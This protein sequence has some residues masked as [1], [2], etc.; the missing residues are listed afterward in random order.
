MSNTYNDRRRVARPR[1]DEAAELYAYD[2]HDRVRRTNNTIGLF[3]GVAF[4]AFLALCG[5]ILLTRHLDPPPAAPQPTARALATLAPA[6]NPY[7]SNVG[8][9]SPHVP[10]AE[11]TPI[12]QPAAPVV[13]PQ[14]APVVVEVAPAVPLPTIAPEQAAIIGARGSGTCPAGQVFYPRS[15]CHV[16]GSGGA[17][18]GPVGGQK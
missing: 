18:P 11:P 7:I 16:T 14:P 12:P 10:R 13:E 2:A 5:Y 1:R 3:A 4:I 17:M 6:S 15:G 8:A 9:Q